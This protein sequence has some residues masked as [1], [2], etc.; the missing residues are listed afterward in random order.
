MQPSVAAPDVIRPWRTAVLVASAVAALELVLI[1]TLALLLLGR[2]LAHRAQA[3]AES[4]LAAKAGLP[5]PHTSPGA[6]RPRLSRGETSVLVLNGNGRAGAA[7]TEA[8]RVHRLGYLVGGV[9]NAPSTTGRTLVMYRPGYR[10]EALR[11]SHDAG[12]AIVEPLDGMRLSDL[13]GA[14]LALIVGS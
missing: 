9:G 2:P 5:E 12:V 7:A 1:L 11:F 13:M 3:A 14:H 8:A 4:K 6:G 10:P